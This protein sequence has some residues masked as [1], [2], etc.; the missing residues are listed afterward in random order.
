MDLTIDGADLPEDDHRA[1]ARQL[2]DAAETIDADG[3][4]PE[5][6]VVR[7]WS[8]HNPRL[9]GEFARPSAI[10]RYLERELAALLDRGARISVRPARRALGLDDPALF[11]AL[12]ESGWDLRAKKL[13]LFGPERM[14]LSLDRLGHYTGTSADAFQRYVVFTNYAMHVDAFRERF[15]DAL[16]P[17]RD[18]VQMPAW[19]HLEPDGSGVS[20]VNI[21]VGPSNAKTVTDHV[22]VLRPDAMLMIGHCGGLR[23]HQAIGDFVLATAYLRA[24]HILDEVLPTSVPVTPNQRLNSLLLGALER[25][26]AAFRLGT[27]YTT[28]NRNWELNQREALEAMRLSRSVAVDMESATVAANGFRYRIPNATLLCVSDKPL[29]GSPK[30]SAAAR[31]FYEA[32][33]RSHLDI[34][35]E[36]LDEVRSRHPHGIPNADLRSTDEPLLGAPPDVD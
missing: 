17:S 4:Y 2:C 14:A 9:T 36:C 10:R 18:G 35:L 19:H 29:H 24:D 6:E 28:D 5:I 20:I 15:P 21:G 16:G 22:A 3:W 8:Q 23:N 11:D 25:R 30:L 26:G 7:P 1:A 12:D 33:R 31:D 13:F 27:V 34:A 32:S